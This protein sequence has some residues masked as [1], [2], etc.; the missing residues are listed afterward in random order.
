[1]S[2]PP[3]IEIDDLV[4]PIPGDTPGGVPLPEP[5]RAELERLRKPAAAA[6]DPGGGKRPSPDFRAIVGDATDAL[7]NTSKDIALV[8]RMT[9]AL[10]RVHGPAGLRDG[11]RLL[12]RV[13]ADCWDWVHPLPRDG[14]YAVRGNR[15]KWL[16]AA[17][18]GAEFPQTVQLMPVVKC[19]SEWFC[20][21][22][23]LDP[24]RAGE[25]DASLSNLSKQ[26]LIA[27][28]EALT[29]ATA[30]LTDL[31][32]ELKKRMGDD[33]A[34]DFT[35]SGKPNLGTAIRNCLAFVADVAGK[36]GVS[37]GP[38]TDAPAGDSPAA[39]TGGGGEEGAAKPARL[40]E[41][42]DALYAQI[43][44]IANVLKR[45][46]PHSPVPF[47]LERCVRLGRMPFPELMR[48]VL[49]STGTVSEMDKL[50]GLVEVS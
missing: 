25:V 14:D 10:A 30:A 41:S 6:A 50:L 35:G 32:V 49:G 33:D 15:Y 44:Q 19:G 21:F 12:V 28:H 1:M 16:N 22:D 38:A 9:E 46:E 26:D 31:S 36:R 3:T 45:I 5:I 4:K 47:L 34:P 42:R 27:T 18:S 37:L 7:M 40:G 11:L 43:E 17:D 13:T 20:Y 48:S 24:A 29:D 2:A 39:A 8:V 23:T